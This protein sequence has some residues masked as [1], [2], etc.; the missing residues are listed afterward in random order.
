MPEATFY[1]LASDNEHQRLLF[2]C[3][4]VE[5]A[6]RNGKYCY[7]LTDSEE[8]SLNLD[9]LL[10]TFR[11]GSFIPHEIYAGVRPALENVI[12]IGTREPPLE[13]RKLIINLSDSGPKSIGQTDR[14]LEVLDANEEIRASGRRRYRLYQQSGIETTTHTL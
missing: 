3:K 10:W 5:K 14:I 6:Y 9:N 1:V 11:Q 2:V 13:W 8:Q 12:L 7:V 4:L